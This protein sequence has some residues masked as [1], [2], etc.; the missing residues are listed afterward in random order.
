M[1]RSRLHEW[2]PGQPSDE[3]GVWVMELVEPTA[4]RLNRQFDT[5]D[6]DDVRQSLAEAVLELWRMGIPDDVRDVVAWLVGTARRRVIVQLL[7]LESGLAMHERTRRRHLA[8]G[9]RVYAV[10]APPESLPDCASLPDID[11][12]ATMADAME[13]VELDVWERAVVEH[14]V[15]RNAP[16][17][18]C[19]PDSI[20]KLTQS[21]R[22]KIERAL[23]DMDVTLAA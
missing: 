10:P 8:A 14:L 1:G 2:V 3:A 12:A 20:R 21:A 5:A 19:S 15:D 4:R 23:L 17:P 13:M 11:I 9:T 18:A 7:D 16:L 22:R 6:L